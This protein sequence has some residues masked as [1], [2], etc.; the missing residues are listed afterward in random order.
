M[1]PSGVN[2]SARAGMAVEKGW[3]LDNEALTTGGT[4]TAYTVTTNQGMAT[5]EDGDTLSLRFNATNGAAP[6]LAPDGGTARALLDCDGV[7]LTGGELK[8]NSTYDLVYRLSNTSWY[9]KDL[10]KSFSAETSATNTVLRPL[11]VSRSTSGT[12][13]AGIGVGIDFETEDGSGNLD[14]VARLDYVSTDVT[15]ASED[16]EIVLSAMVAGTVTEVARIAGAGL[17]KRTAGYSVAGTNTN[18]SASA[19][20]VGEL[21]EST[22]LAG[23]AVG[24]TTGNAAN[25]TSISLTAGDW[26]VF[27]NIATLPAG[28][29]TTSLVQGAINTTSAT[30]P[31]IPGSGTYASFP[32]AIAAGIGL[33]LQVGTRR[34]L[35]SGTT[36]VYLV[37]FANFAVSTM[38]AYGY[39]GARRRR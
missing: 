7:A 34:L 35:L 2:N 31:T 12:A 38:G 14:T 21:I 1:L 9:I 37:A 18:D 29:T 24:L 32:V 30:L 26:D 6:T 15:N 25:V 36:T 28:G 11:K 39:I 10:G 13:A 22:V 27:G 5:P 8:A 19:G 4:S 17:L 33:V 16:G 3:L 23:S 20:Y